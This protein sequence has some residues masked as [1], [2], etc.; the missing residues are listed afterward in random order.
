MADR[1]DIPVKGAPVRRWAWRSRQ[2]EVSSIVG[3]K[4]EIA[5]WRVGREF[6]VRF[7][8]PRPY[9]W[10]DVWNFGIGVAGPIIIIYPG[11]VRVGVRFY[12]TEKTELELTGNS[13]VCWNFDNA[14]E[15]SKLTVV[16][17]PGDLENAAYLDTLSVVRGPLYYFT[18]VQPPPESAATPVATLKTVYACNLAH[19]QYWGPVE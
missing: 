10:G 2:A 9:P 17:V 8:G 14:S 12:K 11:A 15:G 19:P 1:P 5:A 16:K 3:Y 18:I 6:H 13:L 7:V 4:P